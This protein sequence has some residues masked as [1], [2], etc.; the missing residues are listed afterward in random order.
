MAEKGSKVTNLSKN[1]FMIEHNLKKKEKPN[2][3]ESEQEQ[4]VCVRLFL[5]SYNFKNFFFIYNLSKPSHDL[6]LLLFV[7]GL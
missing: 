2:T 1:Y 4:Q 5:F 3:E 6:F 7:S